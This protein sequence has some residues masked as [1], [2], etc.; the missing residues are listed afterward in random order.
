MILNTKEIEK[1]VES[2]GALSTLRDRDR[3]MDGVLIVHKV[4]V[5]SKNA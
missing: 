4:P 1:E 5:L 2:N 3:K